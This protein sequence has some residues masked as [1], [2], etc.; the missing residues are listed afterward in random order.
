MLLKGINYWCFPGSFEDKVDPFDA[1]KMTKKYGYDALELCIGEAG[2]QFGLD[3][4]EAKCKSLVEAAGNEGVALRT[5]ASG[6]YWGRSMGDPDAKVREQAKDDLKRMLQISSWLGCKVH[7]TIPAAV[8]VFFLPD[9]PVH[10][11]DDCWKY[12]KDGIAELLPHAE[13]CGVKMGIEN[14]W[15]KMFMSPG[16]MGYFISQFNSPWIGCLFDVG[17]VMPFGYPEQ[18]IRSLGKDIVAI[19]FKDFRKAV[20][21]AEG[22]V[23]LLEGDVNFPEVIKALGEIGFDGPVV[24]EMIPHY[25]LY[26]IARVENTSNAMDHIL[27]RK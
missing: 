24:A 2:T 18:W 15:N 1:V 27:G 11:Y 22:F 12:A 6:I 8:D 23:D 19:H 26:P 4:D 14:V 3:A 17:N 10:N 20:G 25:K 7:L 9:R 5:T 21:T 16:E 13:A